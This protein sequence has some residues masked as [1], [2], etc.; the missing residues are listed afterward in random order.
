[1]KITKSIAIGATWLVALRLVSRGLGLISTLILVRLLSPEDFG[2]NAIAMS[3]FALIDL[4]SRFGFDTVLIQKQDVQKAHYDTAWTFNVLFGV[5]A[6]LVIIVSSSFVADFYNSKN[7]ENILYVIS[8]LFLLN[9]IVN[10]G[11]VDFRKNLTFE[12]EFKLQIL[13]KVI[14]FFCTLGLAFW[15]RNYWALILG[16]LIWKGLIVFFSYSF[17]PYR[18]KLS[19]SKWKDLFDFSKWIFLNNFVLYFNKQS[20]EL[21]VGKIISPKAAGFISIATE[22]SFLA[23][24]ELVSSINRAAYPGYSK[25]SFNAKKL[26]ELY[27]DV[28]SSISLWVF[29]AGI[30][31][32]SI[33]G[34][35][36]PAF[37]GSEW[38]EMTGAIN[39]LAIASMLFALNSNTGYVFLATAKPHLTTYI[40]LIRVVIFLPLLLFM[41]LKWGITG[42]AQ[43]TFIVSFLTYFIYMVFVKRSIR[44][45]FFEIVKINF[46][47]LISASLMYISIHCLFIDAISEY[48]SSDFTKLVLCIVFGF[49]IYTFF[50]IFLWLIDGK[51]KGP[52]KVVL[53]HIKGLFIYFFHRK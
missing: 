33:S 51:Q 32:A 26:K 39:Y 17:H 10:I 25:V 2:L 18:P 36:V 46:K 22:L 3:I 53:K 24:G 37:M 28:I 14:S 7:L 30:G 5:F 35:F 45:S 44:L 8:I 27:I 50:M 20:P 4:F 40:S 1:M 13:P 21:L 19:L 41:G 48:V 23:T 49:F 15:F 34:L 42:A 12:K 9:G 47:P 29:P 31:L 6:C 16:S 52:E 38:I 43:A 11:T